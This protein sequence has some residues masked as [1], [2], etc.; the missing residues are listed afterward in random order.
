MKLI[1][2]FLLLPFVAFAIEPVMLNWLG[3]TAPS[4]PIGVSWGVPWPKG[5]V[6]PN[7][8]MRLTS[9]DGRRIDVQT[10]SVAFWPDGS[11]KWTGHAIA[12][13]SESKAGLRPPH[14]KARSRLR[15]RPPSALPGSRL[16]LYYDLWL[17]LSSL[18][19]EVRREALDHVRTWSGRT[20][21]VRASHRPMTS[22]EVARLAAHPLMGSARTR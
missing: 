18:D 20:A 22:E 2:F 15:P 17:A 12:V 14:S 5:A 9:A 6:Q 21:V 4:A 19:H 13:N 8:P 11:V 10:W 3:G 1:S 16:A 7:T